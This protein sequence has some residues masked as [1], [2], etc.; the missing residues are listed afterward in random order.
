MSCTVDADGHQCARRLEPSTGGLILRILPLIRR[1]R[2][3]GVT[4]LKVFPSGFHRTKLTELQCFRR[5]PC[6]RATVF[7]AGCLTTTGGGRGGADSSR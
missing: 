3:V 6:W 1:R 7:S 4:V 5:I 2:I